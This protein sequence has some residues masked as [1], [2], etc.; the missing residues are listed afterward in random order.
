MTG[1]SNPMCITW[2]NLEG[3]S[4]RDTEDLVPELN[5]QLPTEHEEELSCAPVV[6]P[7][8]PGSWRNSFL[9]DAQVR[10]IQQVPAVADVS[11]SVVSSRADIHDHGVERDHPI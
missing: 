11:P 5:F 1:V 6:M 4:R 9:R 10:P 2:R 7:H 3:I 8:L